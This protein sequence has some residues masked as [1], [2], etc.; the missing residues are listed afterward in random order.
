MNTNTC[1][2]ALEYLQI[3]YY[4]RQLVSGD[5]FFC[6]TSDGMTFNIMIYPSGLIR[7]WRF[8]CSNIPETLVGECRK[9][10]EHE[11]NDIVV[12][13]EVTSE[14]DLSFFTEQVVDIL[15]SKAEIYVLKQLKQFIAL[16]RSV[17]SK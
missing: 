7:V 14:C 2:L 5:I 9:Y 8:V 15:D 11:H 6:K 13:L 4:D 16:S 12:G 1:K 10:I 3:E 17:W